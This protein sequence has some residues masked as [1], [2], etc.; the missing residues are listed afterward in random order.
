[1]ADKKVV[2]IA[3][4]IEDEGQ[5]DLFVGQRLHPRSPYEFIDMSVKDA[6]VTG[7]K[8][9]VRTRIK[10]SNGVIAL[11]SKNSA[12]STGQKWEIECA[13]EEGIPILGI[14]AYSNDRASIAGIK[15]VE[16]SDVNITSFIDGL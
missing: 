16:W 13:K 7:W 3:F 2:F 5:R 12:A 4:A 1:M 15:T 8:D 11:V 6:Y 9:K 14:W 10:R